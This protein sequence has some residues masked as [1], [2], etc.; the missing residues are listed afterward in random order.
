MYTRHDFDIAR[1]LTEAV[2]NNELGLDE[3]EARMELA[4]DE[5]ERAFIL[6]EALLDGHAVSVAD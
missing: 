5:P 1:A 4:A 2:Q 6:L 3:A